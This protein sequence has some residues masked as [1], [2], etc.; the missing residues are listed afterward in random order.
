[1]PSDCLH[2]CACDCRSFS[3]ETEKIVAKID[4][5]EKEVVELREKNEKLKF[6]LKKAKQGRE[7]LKAELAKKLSEI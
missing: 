6:E 4:A 1:M 2:A 3:P 5:L 7:Q